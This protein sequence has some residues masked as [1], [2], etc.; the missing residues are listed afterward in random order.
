MQ[1]FTVLRANFHKILRKKI[2]TVTSSL[3]IGI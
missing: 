1:S 3:K 2:A